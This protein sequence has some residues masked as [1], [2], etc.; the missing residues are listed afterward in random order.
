M[1]MLKYNKEAKDALKAGVD[2]LA[3]AVKVTLGPK[4]KNVIINQQYTYPHI[5]KDGVTVA[6]AVNLDDPFENMAASL[7]KSVAIKTGEDAGDGTT[8]A[9]VLTQAI[10]NKSFESSDYIAIKRDLDK[11]VEKVVAYIKSVSVPVT[12][13]TIEQVA[14]ISANND[15][16]IGHL[17]ADAIRQVG[18]TGVVT[19]EPGKST[20]TY[21]SKVQGMQFNSGYQ[22]AYFVTDTDRNQCILDNPYIL[23][24]NRKI[25]NIKEFLYVLQMVT[26]KNQSLLIICDDIEQELLDTIVINRIKNNLKVCVVK[27][28]DFGEKRFEA[29]RDIAIV[30]GAKICTEDA[31][32]VKCLGSCEKATI[33]IDSAT[34]VNG[35]GDSEKIK[36]YIADISDEKRIAKMTGGVA[37]IY[38]GA[39]SETEMKEKKDRIEDALCAAKAAIEEGTVIGGSKTY[40]DASLLLKSED[41]GTQILK[42]ALLAPFKQMCDNAE[43]PSEE[44]INKILTNPKLM[45]NLKTLEYEDITNTSVLDPAKV[46]RVA[47]EN[48]ASVAGMILTTECAIL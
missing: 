31:P 7:V 22:S 21:I 35:R 48:A 24:C 5:T 15:P 32:A 26:E 11:A 41:L 40:L 17:I 34:L 36:E 38:V 4:G 25:D 44:I 18:M 14:T 43:I 2:K 20:Q 45:Y 29:L 23:I 8:T 19:I 37:V 3:N 10:L 13:D 28:P 9:T 46:A 12:F 27:S 33:T 42:E 1:T 16:A 47:L 30:T 39:N 6:K